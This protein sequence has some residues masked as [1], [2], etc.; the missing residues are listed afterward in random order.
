MDSLR[1]VA[2]AAGVLSSIR[3]MR[4]R[5]RADDVPMVRRGKVAPM[6]DFRIKL[7]CDDLVH[8]TEYLGSYH[9]WC[10]CGTSFALLKGRISND[11]YNNILNGFRTENPTTC[12]R[13]LTWEFRKESF[14]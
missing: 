8:I 9:G 12:L 7:T 13:C 4:L 3:R 6:R 5:R 2:H 11:I 14:G 1:T 10:Q